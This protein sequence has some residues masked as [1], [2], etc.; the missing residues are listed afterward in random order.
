MKTRFTSE[1]LI[2]K[3]PKKKQLTALYW[4]TE[5]PSYRP[6]ILLLTLEIIQ[7]EVMRVIVALSPSYIRSRLEP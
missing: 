7:A 6:K 1:F 3:Y 2:L 4:P 5:Q